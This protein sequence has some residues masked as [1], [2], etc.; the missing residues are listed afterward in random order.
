MI[1]SKTKVRKTFDALKNEGISEEDVKRVHSP[2][3]LSIGAKTAQEIAVAIVA[4][5]TVRG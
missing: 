4:G 3:G 2:I 5:G 1:G